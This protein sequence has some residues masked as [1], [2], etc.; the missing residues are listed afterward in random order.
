MFTRNALRRLPVFSA[1]S[2]V[3]LRSASNCSVQRCCSMASTCMAMLPP[4]QGCPAGFAAL[5]SGFSVMLAYILVPTALSA[6]VASFLKRSLSTFLTSACISP[7]SSMAYM[8][9]LASISL[10]LSDIAFISSPVRVSTYQ[11]PPAGSTGCSRSNSSRSI[12]CRLRAILLLVSSL[13]PMASSS[14]ETLM[15]FIPPT[16]PE[17]A[18]VVVRRIFT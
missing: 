2:S 1:A 3:A 13:S 11:L 17:K 15:A 18:S 9:P 10:N 7:F 14:V 5:S 16:T 4:Q 12:S 6:R 8:P